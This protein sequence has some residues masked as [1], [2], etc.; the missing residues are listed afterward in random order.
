MKSGLVT[1][2]YITIEPIVFG[3]GIHLFN[4]IIGGDSGQKIKLIKSRSTEAGTIFIE[5]AIN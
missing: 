4:D 1:S 3:Q 5:Y 2:L